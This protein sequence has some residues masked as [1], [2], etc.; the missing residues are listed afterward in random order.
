MKRVLETIGEHLRKQEGSRKYSEE[1]VAEF[2]ETRAGMWEEE[3]TA[4]YKK[5]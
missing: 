5:H 1:K 2:V 3:R 4:A